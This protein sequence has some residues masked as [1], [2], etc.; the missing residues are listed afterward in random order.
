[1]VIERVVLDYLRKGL[2][3]ENKEDGPRDRSLGNAILEW[4]QKRFGAIY[5]DGLGA[6]R[7]IG[8]ESSKNSVRYTGRIT[9]T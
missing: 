5:R 9:K 8:S 2:S 7:E 6:V 3:V 1:M 4:S